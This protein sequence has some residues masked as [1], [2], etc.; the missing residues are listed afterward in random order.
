MQSQDH[1]RRVLRSEL[2]LDKRKVRSYKSEY[3]ADT[4][5][6]RGLKQWDRTRVEI[7]VGSTRK[8][9]LRIDG[10]EKTERTYRAVEPSVVSPA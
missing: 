9:I 7:G 6:I 4:I 10:Y 2:R 3:W 1:L 8:R 5:R